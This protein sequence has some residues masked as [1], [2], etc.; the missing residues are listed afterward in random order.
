[1]E[2]N[3][4][5]RSI[6]NEGGARYFDAAGMSDMGDAGGDIFSKGS[7][8]YDAQAESASPMNYDGMQDFKDERFSGREGQ[9]SPLGNEPEYGK[10]EIAKPKGAR[11]TES[12]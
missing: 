8:D 2:K 10:T 6:R 1:M 3:K 11:Y 7:A 5:S 12:D 4:S 9:P